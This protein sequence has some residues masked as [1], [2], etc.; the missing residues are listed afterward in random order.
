M[1]INAAPVQGVE[2]AETRAALTGAG[3][4]VA[5]VVIHQRKAYSARMQEG[6]TAPEIEPKG[7]AAEEVREL[8]L[9]FVR[10]LSCYQRIKLPS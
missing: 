7:K 9:W 5:P 4:E 3:V 10:K 6:R 2:T 8:L 1:L